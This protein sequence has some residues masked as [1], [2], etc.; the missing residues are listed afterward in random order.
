MVPHSE[1]MINHACAWLVS[2]LNIGKRFLSSEDN[3][4]IFGANCTESCITVEKY[5]SNLVNDISYLERNV[6]EV[7]GKNVKFEFA[8]IPNDMKMLCFLTGELSNSSKY[9]STFGNV[10]YDDMSKVDFTFGHSKNSKWKPW[11]YEKRLTV[12]KKVVDLEKKA[13]QIKSC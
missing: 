6:F 5:V 2:F 10:S 11:A 4:F 1:R 8:E 7:N 13:C 12:A 9:F 3:F